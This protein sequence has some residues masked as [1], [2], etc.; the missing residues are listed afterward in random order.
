[1]ARNCASKNKREQFVK[2]L[3]KSPFRVDSLSSC[4]KNKEPQKGWNMKNKNEI[5]GKYLFHL[6]FENQRVDD[7]ITEKLWGALVAGT[8]PV[9]FGA[10]NIKEHVPFHGVIF[11]DD[12]SS[13]SELAEYLVK[14]ANDRG[15]YESY[16]KWRKE[17]LPQAWNDKYD[18]TNTHS[19][20]RFCRWGHAKKYGLGWN[21]T[22]QEIVPIFLNSKNLNPRELCL[23]E[24]DGALLKPGKETWWSNA[25]PLSV[26]PE[27][28][29]INPCP[30]GEEDFVRASVGEEGLIR[31][32]W[33]N[34]GATDILI[35]GSIS[36]SHTLQLEFPIKDHDELKV[37]DD[38]MV[39]IQNYASRISIITDGGNTSSIVT[40]KTGTVSVTLKPEA[41]PLQVRII[42]ENQDLFH[43]G[44]SDVP[45]YYSLS[46]VDDIINPPELF[47][48]TDEA[49][50]G[51]GVEGNKRKSS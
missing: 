16:H 42:V 39:W 49:S 26:R 4:L 37:I 20:C 21:H 19:Q 41:L 40:A 6:S 32:V 12:Y 51:S 45:S 11:A 50:L 18:L 27:N 17:P 35:D 44:A 47:W 9:Y 7:Y 3:I 23:H 24:S 15:L 33:T 10:S 38:N 43:E 31:S 28:N 13:R 14:V 34:D 48:V 29:H 22:K 46:M 36:N 30:L 5:M 25:L 1:M 8:V 2:D